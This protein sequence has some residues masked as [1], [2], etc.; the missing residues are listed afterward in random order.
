MNKI[1]WKLEKTFKESIFENVLKSGLVKKYR[2]NFL[3]TKF[4]L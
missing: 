2:L 1:N 4:S 3:S